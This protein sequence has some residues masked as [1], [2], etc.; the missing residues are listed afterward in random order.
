MQSQLGC[1]L[2]VLT[3]GISSGLLCL[4]C[5]A[6]TDQR[7]ISDPRSAHRVLAENM[8][9]A[10]CTLTKSDGSSSSFS[11]ANCSPRPLHVA[12]WAKNGRRS[13]LTDARKVRVKINEFHSSRSFNQWLHNVFI[14][15]MTFDWLD[16]ARRS[17]TSLNLRVDINEVSQCLCA[18]VC[19]SVSSL[20]GQWG[21]KFV[22]WSIPSAVFAIYQSHMRGHG[23]TRKD[24]QIT[25]CSFTAC[26]LLLV[27]ILCLWHSA[28][29]RRSP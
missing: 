18:V 21:V 28:E 20:C 15:G 19:C 26:L 22:L 2:L 8:T 17:I 9:S 27:N 12:L 24:G 5:E 25:S 1:R 7:Q 6:K 13:Q 10:T 14:G 4:S 29:A 11:R 23:I 16:P 3:F